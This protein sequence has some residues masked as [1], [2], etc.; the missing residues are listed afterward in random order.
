MLRKP[1]DEDPAFSDGRV[2]II[3]VKEQKGTLAY[4]RGDKR[5]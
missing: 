4:N 1:D 3:K 5:I 2:K